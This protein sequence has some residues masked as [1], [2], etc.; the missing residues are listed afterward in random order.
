MTDY[1]VRL[2]PLSEGEVTIC[3]PKTG[4]IARGQYTCRRLTY[5]PLGNHTCHISMNEMGNTQMKL[6]MM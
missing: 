2:L 5:L 6:G 3:S 1:N 4:N